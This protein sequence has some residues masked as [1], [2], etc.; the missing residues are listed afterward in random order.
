MRTHNLKN[1]NRRNYY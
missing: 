1:R